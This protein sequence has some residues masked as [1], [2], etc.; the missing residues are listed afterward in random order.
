MSQ[1][2]VLEAFNVAKENNVGLS[3]AIAYLTMKNNKVEELYSFDMD[4]GRLKG[5]RRITE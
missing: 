2:R 1:K 4:F 5:I 3:G